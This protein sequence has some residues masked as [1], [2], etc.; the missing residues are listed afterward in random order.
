MEKSM[1]KEN[2]THQQGWLNKTLEIT[3]EFQKV[4]SEVKKKQIVEK[5]LLESLK[6]EIMKIFVPYMLKDMFMNNGLKLD[7]FKIIL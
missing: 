5:N 6:I 7:E 2:Y 3:S 4:L 1:K